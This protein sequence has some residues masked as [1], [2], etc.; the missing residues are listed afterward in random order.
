[1]SP[2]RLDEEN[3]RLIRRERLDVVPTKVLGLFVVG[4][5]ARRWEITV[6]LSRTPAAA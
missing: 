3:A 5:L 6:A 2:E 4:T 1:M